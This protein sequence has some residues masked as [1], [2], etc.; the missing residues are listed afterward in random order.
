ME[1]CIRKVPKHFKKLISYENNSKFRNHFFLL[2]CANGFCRKPYECHC[3]EGWEGI[4][5]DQRNQ[6]TSNFQVLF[7]ITLFNRFILI[8]HK[9]N[10][11]QIVLYF[12]CL[13]QLYLWTMSNARNVPVS[14]KQILRFLVKYFPNF[15]IFFYPNMYFPICITLRTQPKIEK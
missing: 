10:I 1:L 15:E 8:L 11:K 4:L 6:K 3:N 13:P 9:S 14:H 12:S 5:C 2:G 7:A